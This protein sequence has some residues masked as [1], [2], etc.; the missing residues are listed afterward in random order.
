MNMP[1]FV[2][3]VGAGPGDPDLL[4]VKALRLLQSADVIVYDRL[5][6]DQIMALVPQNVRTIFAGKASGHHALD[7][8]EI[9]ELLVRLAEEGGNVVRLKGGDPYIFGRG[10]EEA[11]YL[12][13][14][15]I[16]FEVV[17]GLTAAQACSAYSGIPLTHRGVARSVQYVTG[18]WRKG[19]S[20]DLMAETLMDPQQTLVVYMGLANLG[21]VVEKLL[22]AGRSASTPVAI[23]ERGTTRDHR[24]IVSRL[25][26]VIDVVRDQ[27]V[28]P[29]SLVIIGDVVA[30]ASEL[31]WFNPDTVDFP[32]TQLRQP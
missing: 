19:D 5:V 11:L 1:P 8:S 2:S 10:S 17:P 14:H 21:L 6:S 9:N 18:H 24:Q 26:N 28:K 16:G 29:P 22:A 23:I 13:Q 27:Q 31:A 25:E 20:I 4:T 3:L 15:N 7:Q 32:R 12:K 30:M